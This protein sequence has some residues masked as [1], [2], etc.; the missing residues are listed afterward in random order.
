MV[1]ESRELKPLIGAEIRADK[2]ELLSGECAG[3]IR[4]LLGQRGV[5]VFPQVNLIDGEATFAYT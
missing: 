1:F 5:P 2:R 3:R 4:G